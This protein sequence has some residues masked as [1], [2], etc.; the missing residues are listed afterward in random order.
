MAFT[1]FE[2]KGGTLGQG[3]FI[4]GFATR[5]DFYHC[6]LPVLTTLQLMDLGRWQLMRFTDDNYR[7]KTMA[8]QSWRVDNTLS[9]LSAERQ[10]LGDAGGVQ[11][12]LHPMSTLIECYWRADREQR[13]Q[14][15][16]RLQQNN[17]DPLSLRL[18]RVITQLPDNNHPVSESSDI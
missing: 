13:E 12:W 6:K 18:A 5:T 10:R 17:D 7:D 8:L 15:I 9:L 4:N 1:D 3:C 2:Y 14:A 11:E 16:L